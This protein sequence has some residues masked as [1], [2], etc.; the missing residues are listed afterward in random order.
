MKNKH[1]RLFLFVAALA[2]CPCLPGKAMAVPQV[3]NLSVRG[4]QAGGTTTLTIDGSG[5]LPEPRLLLA[6]P[7]AAQVLKPGATDN[8]IQIAV[9]L[10]AGVQ[11]GLYQLHI[12]NRSGVSNPLLIGVDALP[13]LSFAPEIAK[14]PVALHGNLP[15]GATLRTSFQGKKGQR[16]VVDVEA[17]RLGSAVDPFME[18]YDPRHVQLSWSQAIAALEGDARLEAILPADGVYS[19]ELHESLY[20]GSNPDF[21]RL[22]IGELA[23]V[24]LTYPLGGRRGSQPSF[25]VIGNA[26]L[27]GT[28]VQADLRQAFG[29]VPL[30]IPGKPGLSGPAPRVLVGDL[31]EVLE[32]PPVA[33]KLQEVAV[34]A[35]INGRISTPGEE[36]RY[37]LL[38]KPGMKLRFEVFANR[39]GAPLDGV[40]AIRNE[41]GADLATGDDGP[42]TI[43][44]VVEYTVP[45]GVT[46]LV[47]ALKDLEGR[48]G[49]SFVYR[50]AVTQADHPDFTLSLFEDRINLPQGGATVRRVRAN[51]AGYKGAIK[52][53]VLG[54]PSGIQVNGDE[55]PAGASDTLLTFST[56]PTANLAQA[57]VSLVGQSTDPNLPL[58]RTALVAESPATRRQ[59]WLRAELGLA[60]TEP[61]PLIIAWDTA[62]PSLPIGSVYAAKVRLTRA[63]GVSGAVRLSL[64]TS[65]IPPRTADGKQDDLNRT[66]RLQGM[67]VVPANQELGVAPLLVP[68]DLPALPYDLAIQ[69]ELLSADSRSVVATAVT[70]SRRLSASQPFAIQL[71]GPASVQAKSG[72]GP[73]GKLSG[74]LVRGGGFLK[75]VTVTLAGLPAELPAPSVTIPGDKSDFDLPVAFPYETKLGPI[76]NVKLVATSPVVP[77]GLLKSNEIPI[78][79]EVVKG[80]PP[81]PPPPLFRVF[82]DEPS[83]G[84]LLFEGDGQ[85]GLET[86]DRYSGAAALRVTSLQRF[87]SKM[88]GWNFKIAEK[89]GNGEFRYLRFAWKKRGGDTI[90]LQLHANGSWGPTRGAPGP[91][92]RYEAGTANNPF[93]A[94]AIR[95]DPHLPDDWVVVTRDLFADFGTFL[96]DGM[97]FTPG[98]GEYG[99]FDHI[100]LARSLDDLKQCPAPLPPQQPYAIFEDQADFVANLLEGAGTATL[101]NGDKYSG[102]SSVKVT[103][104][105]RFNERLPGLNLRIRQNPGPGEYRFLRFAWKKKGGET[106]CLQ[107][108]HDGQWGPIG[109]N[110]GKFRYHAGPGPECYGGSLALDTK[111]PQNWTV[112]TRDLFADFGEFTLTGIALSPVDGE[113]ALF[114]HL[115]LGKTS[116]DFELVKPKTK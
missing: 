114:D 101:E 20:R 43:D 96:L 100:Y 27:A 41:A 79:V 21:F 23:Y 42:D 46:A 40:L 48:G 71:V 26:P 33:G 108:N 86:V 1:W 35:I 87:R 80:D 76:A 68:G 55:I 28:N 89:P 61:A 52:L 29:D 24:D 19:V 90:M 103:P 13:Q 99:L 75:P 7:V 50:L 83:F 82:D 39:A 102:K 12:A 98:P 34:P 25:E 74:K 64:L 77:M 107:L 30:L 72:S 4:L 6:I 84:A 14:L 112:V 111:I 69:A 97:A 54:L 85:V 17:R 51:R 2:F 53:K 22:K 60:V 11:P 49:P 81:P 47:V 94:A 113:F 45:A 78:A 5:L 104:D 115:Y 70:P 91:S 37:R 16:L 63:K 88:P 15:D 58:Y 36:D 95:V 3:G 67:P 106:I 18:L 10:A 59:P 38:V 105:Q 65:Q 66:L 8:R 116:R 93:N 109:S 31:P 57:L 92:F 56:P 110:P 32:A 9:T 44:P 62:D 73:T